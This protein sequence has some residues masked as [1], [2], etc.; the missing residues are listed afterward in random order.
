MLEVWALFYPPS[1]PLT[2]PESARGGQNSPRRKLG[3][4][5][6]TIFV[7][8]EVWRDGYPRRGCGSA[9]SWHGLA[10]ASGRS[11]ESLREKLGAVR[12]TCLSNVRRISQNT[13]TAYHSSAL[14]R[15]VSQCQTVNDNHHVSIVAK[16]PYRTAI[17]DAVGKR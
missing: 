11:E 6:A 15:L 7:A 2:S 8:R 10:L 3:Q 16:G 1:E 17:L 4:G 14:P 9:V 12:C 5:V 13:K